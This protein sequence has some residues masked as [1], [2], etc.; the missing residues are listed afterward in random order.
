MHNSYIICG[1]A[2]AGKTEI[3]TRIAS[4]LSRKYIDTGDIV[5]QVAQKLGYKVTH[6][7]LL[8]QQISKNDLQTVYT[9]ATKE[10]QNQLLQCPCILETHLVVYTN[11]SHIGTTQQYIAERNVK[12]MLMIDTPVEKILAHRK[13]DNK[14]GRFR[15]ISTAQELQQQR[16][17]TLK[18]GMKLERIMAIPFFVVKNVTTPQNCVD[19]IFAIF[20]QRGIYYE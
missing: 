11:N 10:V 18:E 19:E 6:K 12:L 14:R 5:Y 13:L 20:K 9:T 1:L 4:L 15:C 16:E 2:G 3:G 17:H 7:D 8:P